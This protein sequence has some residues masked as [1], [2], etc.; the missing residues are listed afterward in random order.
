MQSETDGAVCIHFDVPGSLSEVFRYR[1]GQHLVL[2]T[3][4]EGEEVRRSYS[5]CSS[6]RD[7]ELKVAVKKVLDGKFSTYANERLRVG[8]Y[9]DVMP[10]EGSFNTRLSPENSKS[11]LAFAAGSG[12]TPILS[13]VKTI[14]EEESQSQVG[15]VYANRSLVTMMFRE[16]LMALKNRYLDRFTMVNVFSR[17]TSDAD[18]LSGRIDRDKVEMLS[19]RLIDLRQADEVYICGPQSMTE[20]VREALVSFGVEERRIHFELFGIDP[21][22]QQASSQEQITNEKSV[23]HDVTVIRDGKKVEFKLSSTGGSILETALSLGAD[24]PFA[25][26]SGV[27]CTCRARVVSGKVRMDAN[28][29]LEPDERKQGYVLACQAHPASDQVVLDYDHY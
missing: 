12:I 5:I 18:T 23:L 3:S 24:L 28:Y 2:R 4:I 11:Y 26:K 25:C 22:K 6:I 14:L 8:D 9:L 10:P 7:Q 21:S 29:A 13:I 17:E 19:S 16:K 27:C 1:Q 20:E 15:L